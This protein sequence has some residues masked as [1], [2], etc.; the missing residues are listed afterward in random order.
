MILALFLMILVSIVMISFSNQVANQVKSTR[1]LNDDRQE[2]YN[3]E[4]E[5]EECI[6]EFIKGIEIEY[7]DDIYKKEIN[8][9]NQDEYKKYIY[10]DIGFSKPKTNYTVEISNNIKKDSSNIKILSKIE[11]I[12][13]EMTGVNE[14][15]PYFD[16]TDPTKGVTFTMKLIE[17]KK[18]SIIDIK[19]Y[20]LDTEELKDKSKKVVCN[21]DYAVKSWREQS[22]GVDSVNE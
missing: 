4:S 21:I 20:N 12:D 14:D 19:L 22:T 6:K 15:E 13:G 18:V 5:I 3:R 7:K 11:S 9:D 10:Y 8:E 17:D 2:M 1:S 16:S